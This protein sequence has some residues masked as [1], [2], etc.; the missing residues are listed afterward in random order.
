M[1][2]NI[3]LSPNTETVPFNY[4]R[5]LIGAFHK[6]L[7]PENEFHD[8]ISLYSIS[9]LQGTRRTKNGF[10]FPNGGTMFIS[11]P[12]QN[13]HTLAISGIFQDSLI[14]WGMRIQ[15]V[16]IRVTPDFGN[17]Q[18]FLAA[19]PILIKR[20]RTEGEKGHQYYFPGDDKADQYLT[21]TLQSKLEAHKLSPNVSVRFDETYTH[22]KIKMINYNGID[23]KAAFCP[24]IVEGDPQAVK[25]AW[26]VGIGSSTGIGFGALR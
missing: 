6:W 25:F 23:I 21:E 10:N 3:Q 12:L 9:W 14:D 7:G 1:R 16:T 5:S 8:D 26:D 13:L 18:R 17:R 11:S 24:V 22:P 2:I 4:Q 15:E 19:S 20:R